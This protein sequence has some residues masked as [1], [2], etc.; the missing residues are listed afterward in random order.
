MHVWLTHG[1]NAVGVCLINSNE[2]RPFSLMVSAKLNI[3]KQQL[4]V[5]RCSYHINGHRATGWP[6]Q[7]MHPGY[8]YIG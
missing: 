7:D 4:G 2:A 6:E 3:F 1:A 5:I 8:W